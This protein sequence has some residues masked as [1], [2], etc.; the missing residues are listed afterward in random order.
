MQKGLITPNLEQ[1]LI[2]V[3]SLDGEFQ[4]FGQ[5]FIVTKLF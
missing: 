5:R 2:V 1:K 4:V 3:Y